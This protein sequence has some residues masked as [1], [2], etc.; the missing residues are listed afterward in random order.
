MYCSFCQPVA[1]EVLPWN[2]PKQ[3]QGHRHRGGTDWKPEAA[4]DLQNTGASQKQAF[5]EQVH[6]LI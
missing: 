4:I 6:K 5:W 2:F 1:R 3:A